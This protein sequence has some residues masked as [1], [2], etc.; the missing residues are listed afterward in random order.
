[1]V[2]AGLLWA[3]FATMLGYIGGQT[4]HE[5]TLLATGL[6][7]LLALG[8]AVLVELAMSRLERRR[9]RVAEVAAADADDIAA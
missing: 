2:A 6:G 4:F 7:M 5:Q 1:V 9:S 3:S 8:F